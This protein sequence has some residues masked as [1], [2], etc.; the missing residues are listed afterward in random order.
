MKT[1]IITFATLENKFRA[2]FMETRITEIVYEKTD[3]RYIIE[4]SKGGF[5]WKCIVLKR[6]LF[7]LKKEEM[8]KLG[9]EFDKDSADACLSMFEDFYLKN[10]IPAK[11]GGK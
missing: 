7:G 3:D 11:D 4:F 9:K 5:Y 2:L 8:K 1:K 6:D 10:A